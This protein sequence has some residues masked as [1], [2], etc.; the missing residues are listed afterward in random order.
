MVDIELTLILCYLLKEAK[1]NDDYSAHCV[2][3]NDVL[4]DQEIDQKFKQIEAMI[5]SFREQKI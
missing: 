2:V 4:N 3:L 1:R 5:E